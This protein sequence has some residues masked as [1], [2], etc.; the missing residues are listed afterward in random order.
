M[1]NNKLCKFKFLALE[2]SQKKE[3]KQWI[4]LY[5][6][7]TPP[8]LQIIPWKAHSFESFLY[9]TKTLQTTTKNSIIN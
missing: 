8:Y 6:T 4:Y 2:Q 7:K 9:S 1:A 5:Q 3:R